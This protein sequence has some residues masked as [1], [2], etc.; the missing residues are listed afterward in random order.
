MTYLFY[1]THILGIRIYVKQ[2][3]ATPTRTEK[4]P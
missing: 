3:M 4:V 2:D 1:F